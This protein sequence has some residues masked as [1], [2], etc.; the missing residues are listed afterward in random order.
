MDSRAL[1]DRLIAFDTVSHRS[2]LDLIGFVR[3]HLAQHGID[4][5]LI[6]DPTGEKA[7][8]W[9]VIGPADRP[10]VILSGHVDVVPV[11]GQDWTRPPFRLTR[12]GSR[13]YGRGTTDM[14]AFVACAIRAVIDAKGRD[15]QVPLILALSHDE[16][17]GCRG[18]GSMIDA[19]KGWAVQPR[20]CIVGEPTSMEAAIGHKG[21]VALRVTCTGRGG[22]SSA[23]P[24][25]LNAIHLA[26]DF[27]GAVRDLQSQIASDGPFDPDYIVPYTTLHVGK[28]S[29]GVQ[30]NV[31][32]H[33][34]VI[35][36]EIRS[37][38]GH[39]PALLIAELERRASA[40]TAPL[41]ETFPEAA[42]T[43]E[44]LWDYPGLGTAPDADVVGFVKSLTGGNSHGKVSYGTEGGMF[45]ERLGLP[46][47]VCGPG[48]MT[49]GHTPDEFIEDSEIDRCEEMLARLTERCVA[50]F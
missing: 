43:I 17:V 44:R 13:L 36:M 38:A 46:T 37:L 23:A 41:R 9:A 30:V 21:K 18:V 8:L 28:I 27:I 2:N 12:E 19:M 16:E 42:I 47:V 29:G 48:A 11:E 50:G 1:L 15:L 22:H 45:A 6:P 35:D 40:I 34:T 5:H 32:A 39:D 10:G 7:N 26:S 3:D 4:S 25:A 14:K 20:L 33:Q 49:Q 31:V 24:L